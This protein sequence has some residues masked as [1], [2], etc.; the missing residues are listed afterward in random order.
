MHLHC[1]CATHAGPAAP[2]E[3]GAPLPTYATCSVLTHPYRAHAS[4][5]WGSV[6]IAHH[7]L[8]MHGRTAV[9]RSPMGPCARASACYD[10][11]VSCPPDW[12]ALMLPAVRTALISYRPTGRS[13][14]IRPSCA[15]ISTRMH[16]KYLGRESRAVDYSGSLISG[17]GKSRARLVL[18]IISLLAQ[19]SSTATSAAPRK[20]H[21]Q[22][23]GCAT[24][25]RHDRRAELQK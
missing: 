5:T 11:L 23:R 18:L 20:L 22:R 8:T 17:R 19:S 13:L 9:W 12:R 6:E 10:P 4:H 1:A 25:Y 16:V 14:R 2:C 24:S 21:R 3:G 15:D 7:H